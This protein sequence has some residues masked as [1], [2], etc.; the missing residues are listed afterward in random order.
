MLSETP[1]VW[2]GSSKLFRNLKERGKLTT[3]HSSYCLYIQIF[4][5]LKNNFATTCVYICV[6]NKLQRK[7]PNY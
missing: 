7:T 6:E 4:L 5:I 3:L 2:K 1:P